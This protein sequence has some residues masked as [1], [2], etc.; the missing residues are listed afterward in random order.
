M[1]LYIAAP[2]IL[3]CSP[4]LYNVL[5]PLSDYLRH[6]GDSFLASIYRELAESDPTPSA[7]RNLTCV[8]A[9]RGDKARSWNKG[10]HSVYDPWALSVDF[11]VKAMDYARYCTH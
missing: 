5:A 4:L 10:S 6:Y 8:H 1:T 2:S 3:I 11:Y 9:R 7:P